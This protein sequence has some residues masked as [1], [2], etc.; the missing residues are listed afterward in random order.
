MTRGR[1][2][3]VEGIDGAGK[4]TFQRALLVHLRRKGV[5]VRSWR[6]PT[7]RALGE[8]AQS[9]GRERPWTAA[10][11]FTLDRATARGR[12][13]K[14]LGR[15][16]VVLSDRSF[17]STLAYQ[18]SALSAEQ[19]RAL[20]SIQRRAAVNPDLVILLRIPVTDALKRLTARGARRAPLE[21]RRTLVRV[22]RAYAS[23]VRPRG[24]LVLDARRP[25]ED[26]VEA[27][28]RSVERLLRSPRHKGPPRG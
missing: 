12:L 14:L 2:V 27:A 24:W 15:T 20:T 13:E 18:G 16:E 8:R 5:R 6:E 1:L 4:S 3:A 23:L 26:L 19:R 11:F 22:A 7:D 25:V 21:R 9:A 10:L 28:T 17:Y